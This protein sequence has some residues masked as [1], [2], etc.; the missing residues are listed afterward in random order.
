MLLL[1]ARHQD[2]ADEQRVGDSGDKLRA[3]QV[4]AEESEADGERERTVVSSNL[5]LQAQGADRLGEHQLA[6]CV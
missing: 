6:D 5:V 4:G 1:E 3:E 2:Q